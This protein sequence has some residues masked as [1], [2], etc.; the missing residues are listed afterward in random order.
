MLLTF[1]EKSGFTADR[2]DRAPRRGDVVSRT[3]RLESVRPQGTQ[4]GSR[5]T[6]WVMLFFFS[7]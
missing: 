4:N 5:P 7:Y 6:V 1:R 2:V 3:A